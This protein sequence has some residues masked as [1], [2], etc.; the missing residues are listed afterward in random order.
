M[1]YEVAKE[2]A[3][4]YESKKDMMMIKPMRRRLNEEEEEGEKEV[5]KREMIR[6]ARILERMVNQNNHHD[7]SLGKEDFKKIF[8]LCIDDSLQTSDFMMM[9]RMIIRRM[10]EHCYHCGSSHLR[11]QGNLRIQHLAGTQL[12]VTSL[13]LVLV[14]V[15]LHVA[16]TIFRTCFIV[17]P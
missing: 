6:C 11:K 1:A 8:S 7:I 9:V 12:T 14:H 4:E 2:Q 10:K 3:E 13:L 5:V 16:W 15:S 17:C